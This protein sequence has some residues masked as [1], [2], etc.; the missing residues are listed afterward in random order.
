[1]QCD[2]QGY[3]CI[4]ELSEFSTQLIVSADSKRYPTVED[5]KQFR[6]PVHEPSS[7]KGGIIPQVTL[8]A[9]IG[10]G[11]WFY[12]EKNCAGIQIDARLDF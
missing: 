7:L 4:Q 1:M 8:E 2:Y 10:T 6:M 9:L 12:C 5:S 11:F 3:M